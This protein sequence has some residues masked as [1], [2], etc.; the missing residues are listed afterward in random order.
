MKQGG[1][2]YSG[3]LGHIVYDTNGDFNAP[4][5]V[6]CVGAA[7]NNA[8]TPSGWRLDPATKT[9]VGSNT[10]FPFP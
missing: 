9:L 3:A 5:I 4:I 1:I 8:V 10:C 2:D 6:W 7:P